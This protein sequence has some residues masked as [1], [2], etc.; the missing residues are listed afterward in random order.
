MRLILPYLVAVLSVTVAS[1]RADEP[2]V[3]VA[4]NVTVEEAWA[5]MGEDGSAEI[6]LVVNNRNIFSTPVIT[7]S[8]PG[9]TSAQFLNGRGVPVDAVVPSHSELYMQ[10]GGVRVS[11]TDVE[12]GPFFQVLVSMGQGEGV[13]VRATVLDKDTP[14]PDHHDYD[15]G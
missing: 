9:A 6:F 13:M 3:V 4:E 8:V 10:P 2:P 11:A 14:V 5:K 1:V 15:H 12:V 7:F